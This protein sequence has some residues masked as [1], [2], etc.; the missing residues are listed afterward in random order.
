MSYAGTSATARTIQSKDNFRD[1]WNSVCV[2]VNKKFD[3]SRLSV[4]FL[5]IFKCVVSL[6]KFVLNSTI[7]LQINL[8]AAH[9]DDALMNICM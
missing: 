8:V 5:S 9:S 4:V 3:G 6:L 2:V 1:K 7:V